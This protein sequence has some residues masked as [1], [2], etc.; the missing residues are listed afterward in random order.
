MP[1]KP[2]NLRQIGILCLLALC[3]TLSSCGGGGG[4][5]G[6]GNVTINFDTQ[7]LNFDV[8]QGSA[9]SQTINANASSTPTAD[10]YVGTVVNGEGIV[11]PVAVIIDSNTH[12][13]I[14]VIPDTSTPGTF[15]GTISLL[16]CYDAYCDKH[17]AGSPHTVSYTVHVHPELKTSQTNVSI[18]TREGTVS[19]PTTVEVQLPD[20]VS[21][22][23]VETQYSEDHGQWLQI[24]NNGNNLVLTANASALGNGDYH[25][26]VLLSETVTGQSTNLNVSLSVSDGIVVINSV[27]KTISTETQSTETLGSINVDTGTVGESANWS[28]VSNQ[29]WLKLPT[30]SGSTGQS[31]NWALDSAA[32]GALPN[33]T[34]EAIV[35]VTA[36]PPLTPKQ[37]VFNITRQLAEI[38]QVDTLALVAGTAG[39]VMVY[40]DKLDTVNNPEALLSISGGIQPTAIT[41]LGPQL[42]QV[43]LPAL[44]AGSYDISIS[45]QS[46]IQVRKG[47][48]KVQD[49]QSYS[50]QAITTN[51]SKSNL[52]WDPISRNAYAI[53]TTN[54]SVIQFSYNNGGFSI[55]ERV[56]TNDYPFLSINFNREHTALALAHKDQS[57][58]LLDLNDLSTLRSLSAAPVLV[59]TANSNQP[60]LLVT[61]DNK[62]WNANPT[63]SSNTGDTI[64]LATGSKTIEMTSNYPV[65]WLDERSFG[66]VS[67]DGRKMSFVA[68]STRAVTY[69]TATG[70]FT[71]RGAVSPYSWNFLS[72]DYRGSRWLYGTTSYYVYDGAF[73]VIGTISLP[74]GWLRNVYG[75]N[76][77]LS[78]DG[79][80]AYVYA[81][82]QNAIEKPRVYVFD[83]ST[84]VGANNPFPVASYITVDDYISCVGLYDST[85]EALNAS[86]AISRDGRTLFLAGDRRFVVLPVPD[87]VRSTIAAS[88]TR[89]QGKMHIL[90]LNNS[91]NQ[92]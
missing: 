30:S 70:Q 54:K 26:S 78:P 83:I 85:C 69:D 59:Y 24:L 46:G 21:M 68:S 22:A 29:T 73:S 20:G 14:N 43:S 32:F 4:G 38:D 82:D 40:G 1:L 86:M 7:T 51:G 6:G 76:G 5:G 11:S 2:I 28:A 80:Y 74:D 58:E 18:A 47:T 15:T 25:A 12:A 91:R 23:T 8:L 56:V 79:H 71:D 60:P 65:W 49:P 42:L 63:G 61:G 84:P 57:L 36:A 33:G 37:V 17:Y 41:R 45:N 53:N 77:I 88:A 81:V 44:T 3:F 16:A 27:I 62:L 66:G 35:T 10:V 31:F 89:K 87:A 52:L 19:A 64:D 9:A 55:R 39:E 75:G 72:V 67:G 50:Y 92:L 34:Y 48:L 13:S 90:R